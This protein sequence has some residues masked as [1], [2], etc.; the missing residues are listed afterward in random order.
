MSAFALGLCAHANAAAA[1]G[2]GFWNVE[3]DHF[4]CLQQN[5]DAYMATGQ[6]PVVIF[7]TACPETDL[8][9]IMASTSKNLEVSDVKT[10]DDS[11]DRPAE[12]I[13]FSRAQMACLA[14]VVPPAGARV[15]Q[16]PKDP[17]R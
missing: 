5:V 10:V 15:L 17:C 7:L 2:D 16:V 1:Q 4:Q 9:K 13:T 12:V 8:V 6:E 14:K 3:A 11:A